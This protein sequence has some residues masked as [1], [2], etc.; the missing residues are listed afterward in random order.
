MN[1]LPHNDV[2]MTADRGILAAIRSA[3]FLLLVAQSLACAQNPSRATPP[4]ER[5]VRGQTIISNRLPAA[6]LIF[7]NDFRYVG[8]QVVN[9]GGTADAEQHVFVNGASS[10]PVERFYWVQYER[11]LPSNSDTYNY[12]PE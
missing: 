9:L 7:G 3:F 2:A 1:A 4:V 8:S 12:R 10:G 5:E 6:D 11:Y